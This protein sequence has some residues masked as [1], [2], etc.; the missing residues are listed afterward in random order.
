M[1]AHPMS[2]PT[3]D[4]SPSEK[5]PTIDRLLIR[6]RQLASAGERRAALR[7]YL[8]AWDLLPD[9]KEGYESSTLILSAVGDLL[10][11]GGDL[12]NALDA[13]LRVKGR[14]AG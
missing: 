9:P 1:V 14:T 4:G 10:H 12:G 2:E 11:E 13:L 8:E 7:A 6:A 5:P 3:A